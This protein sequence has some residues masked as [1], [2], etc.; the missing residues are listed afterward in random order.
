MSQENVDL[1]KK[2][3]D[4]FTNGRMDDLR[5][6]FADDAVWVSSDEL[7]AG[8][9]INGA[10]AIIDAFAQI[11]Q[12][13]KEFAVEPSEFID[14]GDWV[15]VRG[16]QSGTGNSGSFESL[17]AHLMKFE[18]GKLVRGEFYGDSAKAVKALG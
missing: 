4:D 13:W 14:G 10:D 12:N 5:A 1:A 17:F 7:P 3:Y 15:T 16:T 2:A 6:L 11:P 18:G 8:G 9:E